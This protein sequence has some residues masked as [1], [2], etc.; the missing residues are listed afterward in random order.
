MNNKILIDLSRNL[1]WAW[2]LD[3]QFLVNLIEEQELDFDEIY[4]NVQMNFWKEFDRNI[5]YFIYEALSQVAYKFIDSHKE[6]FEDESDEYEIYTNYLDSH[7]RFTSEIIQS[8][9]ERF[10]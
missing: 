7:I 10:Y 4:E 6:L 8:E 2:Y 5:N 3:I 1:L 9:F